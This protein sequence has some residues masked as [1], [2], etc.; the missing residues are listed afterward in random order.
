MF[1]HPTLACLRKARVTIPQLSPTH[2]RA[3]LLEFCFNDEGV[4]DGSVNVSCYDPLFILECSPD[5]ISEGFRKFP[6]HCPKMLVESQEEGSFRRKLDIKLGM[7]YNV[8]TVV[9]EIDDG[10]MDD[11]SE[12]KW[13][14]QA[15]SHE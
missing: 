15:Y 7:W 3:R 2:T 8:E 4:S 10:D 12:D 14:W 1:L 5:M 6:D 13:L 11:P 9:G